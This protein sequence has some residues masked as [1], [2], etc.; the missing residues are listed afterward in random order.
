MAMHFSESPKQS[1]LQIVVE[2]LTVKLFP[3]IAN[4][5]IEKLD[6]PLGLQKIPV[7]QEIESNLNSFVE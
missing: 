3:I 5:L 4:N 7:Y 2:I 6:Y 1:W